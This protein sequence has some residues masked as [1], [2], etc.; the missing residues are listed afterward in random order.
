M[1]PT[2][3]ARRRLPRAPARSGAR[4]RAAGELGV[5]DVEPRVDDGHRD[6]GAGRRQAVDPDLREP[7][8]LRLEGS[9]WRTSRRGRTCARVCGRSDGAAVARASAAASPRRR[10][11]GARGGASHR[12]AALRQRRASPSLRTTRRLSAETIVAGPPAAEGEPERR[13]GAVAAARRA[14]MRRGMTGGAMVA[15]GDE[16]KLRTAVKPRLQTAVPTGRYRRGRARV[17]RRRS[18]PRRQGGDDRSGDRPA[19]GRSGH[20]GWTAVRGSAR[21]PVGAGRAAAVPERCRRGLRD[22]PRATGAARCSPL[23]RAGA[24]SR[25]HRRAVGAADDRPRPARPR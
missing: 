9:G 12:S 4:C 1:R 23:C 17:R 6:A 7:P 24:R 10:A 20:R 19:G 18:E 3:H 22:P 13:G 8:L 16:E 15:A 14:T 21:Q 11:G 5:R 2:C 25:S